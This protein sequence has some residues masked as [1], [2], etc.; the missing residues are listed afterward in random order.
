MISIKNILI[1]EDEQVIR[2]FI[3]INLKRSGYDTLEADSGEMALELFETQ[4]DISIAILDVML[5]GIDGFEVCKKI[6]EKSSSVGIIFL[7]AKSQEMDKVTGLMTGADDYIQKPFSPAELMARVD[8]LYRR[9]TPRT[10]INSFEKVTS[11][12]FSINIPSRMISKDNKLLDLTQVEYLMLKC[13]IENPEVALSREELLDKIWGNECFVELKVVDVNV[14]R[15][16]M[17][18]EEDPS[19]PKYIQTIWGY[20]Y[21]WGI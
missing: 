12:P 10:E 15:L 11:G 21:K 14:R 2:E 9:V 8:A 16:R 17:K 7:T 20:G 19:Q 6:R 1:C 3:V 5:P 18:I 13:F 4:K